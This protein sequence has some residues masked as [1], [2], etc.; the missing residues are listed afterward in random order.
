MSDFENLEAKGQGMPRKWANTAEV[1][2]GGVAYTDRLPCPANENLIADHFKMTTQLPVE[3]QGAIGEWVEHLRALPWKI[4]RRAIQRFAGSFADNFL[5]AAPN[6]SDEEYQSLLCIGT[7]CMIE[8]LDDGR[9]IQNPHQAR[10]YL[11][12]VHEHHQAMAKTYL[13]TNRPQAATLH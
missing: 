4:R 13:A 12:S 7:T 10:S 11:E 3:I 5:A 1:R 2:D 6:L 9:P 8:Q